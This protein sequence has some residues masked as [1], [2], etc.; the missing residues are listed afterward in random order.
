MLSLIYSIYDPLGFAAP[1]I[2]PAK[3]LLQDLCKLD[4]G[5]ETTIP[6]E[7]LVKW[8]TWVE[9]LPK[10]KLVSWL[11]CFKPKDFGLVCNIQLRH[12]CDASEQG[13]GVLSCICLVDDVGSIDYGLVMSKS[14]VAPLKAITIPRMELTAV[15]VSVKLHKFLEEQLKLP[16]HRAVFWIDST[17]VLQYI[18]NEARRFQM[19]MANRLS[20]IHDASSLS[21]WHHVDSQSNPADYASRGFSITETHKLQ[22]WLSGPALLYKE[23]REWPKQPAQIPDLS[24]EDCEL[25]QRKLQVHG[26][27]QK[28]CLQSL[29]SHFSSLYKLQ[30]SDAWLLSF[31]EYL[32]ARSG[33]VSS[34]RP[35]KG[36]LTVGE[37]TKAT[38]EIVKVIQCQE[39]PNE[40]AML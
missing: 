28:D 35:K 20:I 22:S 11:R 13:Y 2:L 14:H 21:Q 12:F 9:N 8:R 19:C 27:V 24:E 26:T 15:A 31:K 23:E 10:L 5:W 6:D 16:V 7:T 36:N 32:R 40:L 37:I 17:I 18:R 1:L 30:I 33:R 4:F 25:K 29:L 38:E 34:E 3:M 39:F